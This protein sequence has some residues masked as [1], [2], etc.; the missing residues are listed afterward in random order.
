MSLVELASYELADFLM[1]LPETYFRLF[2]THNQ[3]WWPLAPIGLLLLGV[4]VWLGRRDTKTGLRWAMLVLAASWAL[5]GHQFLHQLY[6]PIFPLV[7]TAAWLF[8]LQA[9]LLLAV[10]LLGKDWRVDSRGLLVGSACA[11]VAIVAVPANGLLMGRPF[12]GLD[13]PLLSPDAT[14]LLNLGVLA[15]SRGWRGWLLLPIPL[16]WCLFS[17]LTYLAMAMPIGALPGVVALACVGYWVVRR[18]ST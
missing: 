1:F 14:A 8:G 12:S 13:W 5:I 3:R 7:E 2:E 15:G 11:L 18:K 16:T 10:G 9:L 6:A 17:G 4:A